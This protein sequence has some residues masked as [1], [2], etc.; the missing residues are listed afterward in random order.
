MR[1][2]DSSYKV[3]HVIALEPTGTTRGGANKPLFIT[4]FNSQLNQN[5]KKKYGQNY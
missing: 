4:A 5:L 3:K 2:T 1:I